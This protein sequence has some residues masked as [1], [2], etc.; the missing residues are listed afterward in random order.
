M[1]SRRQNRRNGIVT[2]SPFLP[3]NRCLPGELSFHRHES[4]FEWFFCIAGKGVQFSGKESVPVRP[5]QLLLIPPR[6]PHVFAA[7]PEGCRCMVLMMPGNFP[8]GSSPEAAEAGQLLAYLHKRVRERGPL[9]ELPEEAARRGG[10]L[11]RRIREWSLAAQFGGTLRIHAALL[12]LLALTFELADPPQFRP[13][14][15]GCEHDEA[16]EQLLYYLDNHFPQR[17]PVAVAAGMA[18]MSRSTFH[19]RFQKETGMSFCLYLNRLRIRAA[20]QLIA[21]GVPVETA[22]RR[23]GFFSRSNFFAQRRSGAD[24]ESE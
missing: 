6:E 17:I 22:A 3:P 9:L 8:G 1:G 4:E 7:G 5:G 14:V 15:G 16:V 21:E 24:G 12:E 23:C 13:E 10:D 19:R 18:G 11:L 20:E 2:L